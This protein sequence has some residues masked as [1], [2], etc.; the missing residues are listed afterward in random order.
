MFFNIPGRPRCLADCV[1]NTSLS[2][3]QQPGASALGSQA[4]VL[5][6]RL[7]LTGRY[8]PCKPASHPPEHLQLHE[9]AA[10]NVTASDAAR[11]EQPFRH[12]PPGRFLIRGLQLL[13]QDL[14]PVKSWSPA[15]HPS[16]ADTL[17]RMLEDAERH[18]GSDFR[19]RWEGASRS[20]T[21]G[22]GQGGEAE[23]RQLLSQIR[24]FFTCLTQPSARSQRVT[25][26]ARSTRAHN[27]HNAHSPLQRGRTGDADVCDAW[28]VAAAD[29]AALA[30]AS[31]FLPMHF[32]ARQGS[33]EG[34]PSR[35]QEEDLLTSGF[36]WVRV[37]L[38]S[39]P[40]F[41]LCAGASHMGA[42]LQLASYSGL[43]LQLLQAEGH[44]ESLEG[45]LD[46]EQNATAPS[47]SSFFAEISTSP[48]NEQQCDMFGMSLSAIQRL[49]C[50]CAATTEGAT[51]LDLLADVASIRAAGNYFLI[52]SSTHSLAKV[53][54][55]LNVELL[56]SQRPLNV[57]AVG[58]EGDTSGCSST[59]SKLLQALTKRAVD[60]T[61]IPQLDDV[62][63]TLLVM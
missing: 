24:P 18:T 38:R 19:D 27:M 28:E 21:P 44:A 55:A 58:A 43:H 7:S 25:G 9:Q 34:G 57:M 62:T 63:H 41:V 16:L 22:T 20:H 48:Q 26:A 10:R 15:W 56:I 45:L 37:L 60:P 3:P 11:G 30:D 6:A 47:P 50:I 14:T 36:L 33:G 40:F 39:L 61:L 59:D 2:N 49:E 29:V 23:S 4:G 51:L 5:K 35:Q 54:S 13:I 31:D 8:R 52:Q 12:N 1:P 17:R 53:I 32:G 46:S 42:F